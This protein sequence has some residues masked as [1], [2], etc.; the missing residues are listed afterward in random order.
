MEVSGISDWDDM[1]FLLALARCGSTLKTASVLNV[2]HQTVSRRINALET[3]M[4]AR[5]VD[6]ANTPW[7]LTPLGQKLARQAEKIEA[8]IHEAGQ[9]ARAASQEMTGRICITSAEL[10]LEYLIIPCAADMRKQFPK[11]EFDLKAS[12]AEENISSG[13]F[14]FA[15]RFTKK[16]PDYL[17]GRCIGTIQ[18][19]YYGLEELVREFDKA[20][21]QKK[22]ASTPIIN[23]AAPH[24]RRRNLSSPYINADTPTHNASDLSTLII[25]ARNGLGIGCV[26]KLIGEQYGELKRSSLQAENMDLDVWLLRNEGSRN[27]KKFKTI[28]SYIC[29][30]VSALLKP[31]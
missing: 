8:C 27:S 2:S 24:S 18:F 23:L 17:I 28:E 30:Y 3:T 20:I 14:D 31:A 13:E 19:A 26:P 21:S 4:K 10:G 7:Q 5:L 22:P 29:D 16:P 15:L 25:A 12:F 6:R 11:L 1:R 9:F